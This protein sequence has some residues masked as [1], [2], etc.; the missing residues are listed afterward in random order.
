MPPKGWR[1]PLADRFWAHV[2]KTD[3]CWFWRGALNADGYGSISEGGRQGPTRGTH[4][5]AYELLVGPIPDGHTLDHLC[6]NRACV[7]PA[8]L[9][10]VTMGE[11]ILRGFGAAA[12]NARKTHCKHGHEFTPENTMPNGRGRK[13]RECHRAIARESMRRR[14]A[15]A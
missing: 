2:E 3:T 14:R 13:C 6:R 5:V 1:T 12:L 11:N 7:N 9:E 4:R 10:P 8:H 15:A